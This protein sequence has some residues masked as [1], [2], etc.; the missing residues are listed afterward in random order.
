MTGPDEHDATKSLIRAAARQYRTAGLHAYCFA[1]G[2]LSFDPVFVALLHQAHIPNGARVLDLGCGQGLL[3]TW[4]RAAAEQYRAGFWPICWPAPPQ[5]LRLRGVERQE[6]E[7]AWGTSAL[8]G[9]GQIETADLRQATFPSSDV[10]VLLDV[11]H[12]FD[13]TDQLAL[14][15]RVAQCLSRRGRILLR[16][17]DAGPRLSLTLATDRVATLLR[18]QPWP[19]YHV[20]PVNEWRQLLDRLGFVTTATPMSAGTPFCNVLLVATHGEPASRTDSNP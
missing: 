5:H 7:S 17:A 12:Y 4:L 16:V 2:K 3:L 18:G 6:R 1:L 13:A 20:R 9:R 10:V 19:S 11:L 8:N 15:Q 14:L